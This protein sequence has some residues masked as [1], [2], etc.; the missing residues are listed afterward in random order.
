MDIT[1]EQIYSLL[2][3]YFRADSFRA[4]QEAIIM[5]TISGGNSLVIMPTGMGK[6][7]CYQL[8]ALVFDGLTVVVSPLISLMKD[9]ADTLRERGIDAVCINSAMSKEE[10]LG[11]YRG[12]EQGRYR[13]LLVAPERFRKEHFIFALSARHV[14]ML[15]ID[16][17][18]CISQW[19]HDF[20]PDYSRIAE[21]R[22]LVGNPVTLALTATATARVRQ[23]IIRQIGIDPA[24]IQIFNEGI[25]R[26]NLHLS[27][28]DVIDEREKF[29]LILEQLKKVKGSRIVYF[30]LIAS[31][32]RF[33]QFLDMKKIRY[34]IYHGRLERK[35]RSAIQHRFMTSTDSVM[36]A[37]N[38]FGMGIDKPDIRAVIHAEIPD[39]LEAYYQEIGRAG[40]DGLPSS[41]LLIFCQDDL[42][43][44]MD[45]LRFKNPDARFIRNSYDLMKKLGDALPGFAY[46][47]L[48]ERLVNRNRGDQRLATV[49]N[50]F[51]RYHVTDGDCESGTLRVI[52]NIP[53]D[54]VSEQR[55]TEKLSLD[56]E[57]LVQIM[58]YIRETVC[59]RDFIHNYFNAP[60]TKCGNCDLC[61]SI[62][63]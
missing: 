29:E 3:R 47:D 55:I 26:E 53:D 58:R 45:F 54:L 30:N 14:S 15:V 48:Q 39:S 63:T 18:H 61:E 34:M 42:A 9:Q 13:I 27:S 62:K 7:L 49:L 28:I 44:Q 41:C 31:I 43:V 19:G 46:D 2:G 60:A 16:E 1:R 4:S 59:R 6:S 32:E 50:L 17:A 21:F 24:D 22:N 40:R 57:R 12:I 23:D 25:C 36:L 5:R 56:R 33:S 52:G 10:R 35:K 11:V 20:R 51:D 37:T 38:A 8:P